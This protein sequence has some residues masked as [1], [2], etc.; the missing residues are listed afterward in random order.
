VEGKGGWHLERWAFIVYCVHSNYCVRGQVA[1]TLPNSLS[2]PTFADLRCPPHIPPVP[3]S[4]WQRRQGR[5]GCN[6]V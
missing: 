4:A 1:T 3:N 6:S 2:I 5:A